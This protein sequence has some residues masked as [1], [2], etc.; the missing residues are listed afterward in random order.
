[1]VKKDL[2]MDP[3]SSWTFETAS[4]FK[5]WQ[6]D[7]R[8]LYGRISNPTVERVEREL[9]ALEGG[10]QATLFGSGMAAISTLLIAL[11]SKFETVVTTRNL[12]G[13]TRT[14][15]DAI[16]PT[17]NGQLIEFDVE[18]EIIEYA[19]KH[20]C[21]I[22]I[23]SPS[24]PFLEVFNIA[25]ISEN[26]YFDRNPIIV[27]NSI[28]TAFSYCPTRLGAHFS[29]ASATKGLSG[30]GDVLAGVVWQNTS[31]KFDLK[32]YRTY[33]GPVCSPEV[34]A[35]LSQQMMTGELR[36][37]KQN[38]NAG[39]IISRLR[40]NDYRVFYPDGCEQDILDQFKI[41]FG[42]VFSAESSKSLEEIRYLMG[43]LNVISIST[44]FGSVHSSVQLCNDIEYRS[45]NGNNNNPAAR[46]LLRF[47]IG[48]GD[49]ELVYQEAKIL[50]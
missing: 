8:H 33:L 19:R 28:A 48:L 12:Y 44:S 1:M 15:F 40:A 11:R 5:R 41:G 7:G 26:L 31:V 38:E 39:Y 47:S 43:T 9:S 17:L 10:A 4:A 3:A 13:G 16:W 42:Q 34:A 45:P 25:R 49:P 35:R 20:R 23:E 24:N 6:D 22:F 2:S 36:L 37:K 32:F 21:I 18:E 30:H 46:P 50:L 14:F 27:D 29:V